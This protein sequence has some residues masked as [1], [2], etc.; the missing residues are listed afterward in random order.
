MLK[1]GLTG[2]IGS[3]KSTVSKYFAAFKVPIIDA[4]EIVHELLLPSTV[5]YKKIVAHFGKD[6]LGGDKQLNRKKLRDTIFSQD[7]ERIWLEKLLHPA[8]RTEMRHRIAKTLAPYC[9]LAVPLLLE[10]KFPIKVDRI[11]VVDCPKKTQIKRIREREPLTIKQA[12]AIINVQID[13]KLRLQKADDIIY[14]NS[15]QQNLR[16]IVKKL[17]NYYLSLI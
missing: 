16:K 7:K 2:G 9:I 15:T 1:I 13:R 10:T 4:D 6:F 12:Q 8:V 14:N 11:L 5:T 17:H 3:G